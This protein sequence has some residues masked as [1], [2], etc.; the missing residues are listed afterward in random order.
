MLRALCT[1]R[2]QTC[3][4]RAEGW[5]VRKTIISEIRRSPPLGCSPLREQVMTFWTLD[6]TLGQG[7]WNVHAAAAVCLSGPG[8]LCPSTPLPTGTVRRVLPG[9]AAA[10][11]AA[12]WWV[13]RT[14]LGSRF[15]RVALY[16]FMK[17]SH[18]EGLSTPSDFQY[19]VHRDALG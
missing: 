19:V 12:G 4:H 8:V 5:G 14:K 10:R 16:S 13:G 11:G 2:V 17:E 9:A 7:A 1:A 15:F 6:L 18:E 3:E